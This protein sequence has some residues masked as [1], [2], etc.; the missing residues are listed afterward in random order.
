M[1]A[2]TAITD[3]AIAAM[4]AAASQQEAIQQ[5]TLQQQQAMVLQQQQQQQQQQQHAIAMNPGPSIPA[6]SA[7]VEVE[8]NVT[9]VGMG[10]DDDDGPGGKH[11]KKNAW[12]PEEDAIL[13]RIVAEEGA[14]HWTKVAAHLPHR[15]G[16]QC[17]ER[18]F[19]HLAPDV[20]KGY[21]T[22]EED[23][24]ILNAVREHGTKWSTIQKQLPGRSDNSIK[25]RYYSAIRKAQRLERRSSGGNP[26][27]EGGSLVPSPPGAVEVVASST[28]TQPAPPSS[29]AAAAH[30]AGPSGPSAAAADVAAIGIDM[31]HALAS[32]M[33]AA[34]ASQH[35]SPQG[36]PPAA[37]RKPPQR[38]SDAKIE[39]DAHG[40]ATLLGALVDPSD[41]AAHLAVTVTAAEAV[42]GS[43]PAYPGAIAAAGYAAPGGAVMPMPPSSAT[44]TVDPYADP[45][46]AAAAAAA[47]AAA[48]AAAAAPVGYMSAPAMAYHPYPGY[49][50][51]YPPPPVVIAPP[52]LQ[53][54]SPAEHPGLMMS[55][56]MLQPV[57]THPSIPPPSHPMLQPVGS[58]PSSSPSNAKAQAMEAMGLKAGAS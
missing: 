41:E 56:P 21:W 35:G 45:A 48:S 26:G 40:R 57:V 2:T 32:T 34:G 20:K 53:P 13:T 49:A 43:S 22:A 14:G 6:A 16:R 37:K 25:N 28:L 47:A 33:S 29:A 18:W 54:L 30:A 27:D 7:F 15:M 4:A 8:A 24:L 39:L 17:R 11:C 36:S 51:A 10:D 9:G 12:T 38:G 3:S 19:N 50:P 44:A 5:A 52:M 46:Y 42:D 1:D 31:R 55:H 58:S 23:R